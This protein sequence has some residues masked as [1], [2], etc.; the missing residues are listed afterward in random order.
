MARLKVGKACEAGE[1]RALALGFDGDGVVGEVAA[2]DR[3]ESLAPRLAPAEARPD[4][5]EPQQLAAFV[6]GDG[7]GDGG[8]GHGEARHRV[9]RGVA[10]GAR[11]F[12][13]FEP[14]RRREKQIAHL[15]SRA[16]IERGGLDRALG[17]AFDREPHRRRRRAGAW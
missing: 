4:R 3:G 6:A 15:D 7:E 9:D 13:E 16:G 14:R 12:Q 1:D 17:A 5:V 11:R 8:V 10:L 2:E